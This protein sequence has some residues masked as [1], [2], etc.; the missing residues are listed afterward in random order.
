MKVLSVDVDDFLVHLFYFFDKTTKHKEE[1]SEFQK[2]TDTQQSKILKHVKTRCLEKVVKHVLQQWCALH[3]YFDHISERD[4][5]ARVM[6]LNQHLSSHLTK[7]VFPFLEFALESMCKFNAAFQSSL[8]KSPALVNRLLKILLRRFLKADVV[9]N[10]DVDLRD[11]LDFSDRTIQL[12]DDQLGIG[13]STWGYFSDQDKFIDSRVKTIF[14]TG[15]RDFY[16]A[17]ATTIIKK[18]PFKDS[19][20]YDVAFLLLV[21]RATVDIAAV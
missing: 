5:S 16:C 18:F 11:D 1:L 19:L 12:P 4:S 10:F 14:F 15:V 7:L 9:Q 13:Q 3:S 8:P 6:R 2:F 17:V 20:V 21:N